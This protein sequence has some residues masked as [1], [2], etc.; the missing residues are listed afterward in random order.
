[1]TPQEKINELAEALRQTALALRV[2]HLVMPTV[3]FGE[4]ADSIDGLTK[5]VLEGR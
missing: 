1:M 4:L 5:A 3:G 2:W